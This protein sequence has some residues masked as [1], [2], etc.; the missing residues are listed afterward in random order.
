MTGAPF[1]PIQLPADHCALS[2]IPLVSSSRTTNFPSLGAVLIAFRIAEV[3]AAPVVAETGTV[4]LPDWMQCT[5]PEWH[6]NRR[7]NPSNTN[8]FEVVRASFVVRP[9]RFATARNY[10]FTPGTIF[11]AN[12]RTDKEFAGACN[13]DSQ[14]VDGGSRCHRLISRITSHISRHCDF[15]SA[16]GARRRCASRARSRTNGTPISICACLNASAAHVSATWPC[17]RIDP[18][19]PSAGGT[20][21]DLAFLFYDRLA[22]RRCT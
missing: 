20:G 16:L 4:Q 7:I 6:S 17:G 5:I 21:C 8:P 10:D 12:V 15:R 1:S 14:M 2:E 9:R 18:A 19:F 22:P 13:C 3:P 11:Y